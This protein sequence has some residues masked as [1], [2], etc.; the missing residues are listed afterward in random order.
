MVAWMFHV[1][2][3]FESISTSHWQRAQRPCEKCARVQVVRGEIYQFR[4]QIKQI[5]LVWYN[6]KFR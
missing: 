4:Y 3:D 5:T 2:H 6:E 1:H